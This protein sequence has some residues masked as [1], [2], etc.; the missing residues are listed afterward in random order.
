MARFVSLGSESNF[1]LS[2]QSVSKSWD[3]Q[4]SGTAYRQLFRMELKIISQTKSA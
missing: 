4:Y 2:S 3:C 1:A